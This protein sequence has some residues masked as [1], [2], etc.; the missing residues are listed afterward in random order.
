MD[1]L[2]GDKRSVKGKSIIIG[3][4][5]EMSTKAIRSVTRFTKR[6]SCDKLTVSGEVTSMITAKGKMSTPL[7]LRFSR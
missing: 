1:Q 4:T 5:S 2:G 7:T 3:N 6:P